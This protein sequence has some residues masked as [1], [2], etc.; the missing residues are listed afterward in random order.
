MRSDGSG[1]SGKETGPEPGGE[2]L[3]P[4]PSPDGGSCAAEMASERSGA[5]AGAVVEA[6]GA[7][8]V[9]GAAGRR[10]GSLFRSG[11]PRGLTRRSGFLLPDGRGG[12]AALFVP[13]VS[14]SG[15]ESASGQP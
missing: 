6:P 13:L 9:P 5:P 10:E 1:A 7:A 4:S 2:A 15:P 11:D 14:C 3:R 12:P 8:S